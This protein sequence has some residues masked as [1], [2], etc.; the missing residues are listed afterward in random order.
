MAGKKKVEKSEPKISNIPVP[1][2]DNIFI[3]PL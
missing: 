1:I 2:S 3:A